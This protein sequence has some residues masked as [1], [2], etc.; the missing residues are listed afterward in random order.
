LGEKGNFNKISFTNTY[1]NST[2]SIILEDSKS[3]KDY[4]EKL[5]QWSEYWT[6]KCIDLTWYESQD[7]IFKKK[8]LNTKL[9][10]TTLELA[11]H[12]CKKLKI[13]IQLKF[14]TMK[15][16]SLMVLPLLGETLYQ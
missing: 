3:I 8:L 14:L 1:A 15:T 12:A 16:N 5:S 6:K 2:L 7:L 9:E 10:A 11:K 4:K 13:L